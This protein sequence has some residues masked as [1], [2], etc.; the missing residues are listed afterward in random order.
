[1]KMSIIQTSARGRRILSIVVM[2]WREHSFPVQTT[3]F[4]SQSH[5]QIETPQLILWDTFLFKAEMF[6]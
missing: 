4:A 1:M 3:M 2:V 5:H 6:W